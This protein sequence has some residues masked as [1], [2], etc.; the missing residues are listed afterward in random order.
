M[1]TFPMHVQGNE[2]LACESVLYGDISI[3]DVTSCLMRTKSS[4]QFKRPSA[5]TTELLV[6]IEARAIGKQFSA[7]K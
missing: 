4:S 7:S 5:N 3:Y 2:C 1:V 6:L